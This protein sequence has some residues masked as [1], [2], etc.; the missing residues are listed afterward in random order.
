M[1]F[2]SSIAEGIAGAI[3]TYVI[4]KLATGRAKEIKPVMYIL[5][6]LFMLRFAVL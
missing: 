5:A 3:I 4:L 1:P 6:V 2:T